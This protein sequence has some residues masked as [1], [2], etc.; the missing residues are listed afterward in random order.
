MKKPIIIAAFTALLLQ[1]CIPSIYPL[2][3]DDTQVFRKEALGAWKGDDWLWTFEQSEGPVY[4]LNFSDE[5]EQAT[6]EVH[7]VKLGDYFFFD[8]YSLTP[9][10]DEQDAA[11]IAPWIRTHSFAKVEFSGK[12]MTVYF[13]D[14]NWLSQLIKQRKIRIKHETTT[15]GNIVLTAPTRDLQEFVKKYAGEKE[16]FADPIVFNKR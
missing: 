2:Y 5:D 12:Q 14:T 6:F 3:S 13:F 1:S 10:Y 8:F 9:K 16:A 15:D 7:L 4:Q 11:I